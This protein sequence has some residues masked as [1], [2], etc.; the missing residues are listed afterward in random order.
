MLSE[1]NK[2]PLMLDKPNPWDPYYGT[3]KPVQ[4]VWGQVTKIGVV[5]KID[6]LTSQ[7]YLQPS[8][9]MNASQSHKTE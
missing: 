2:E 6:T 4:V 1:V 8:A 7:V 5:N 3:K 9:V